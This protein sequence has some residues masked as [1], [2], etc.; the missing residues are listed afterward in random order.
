MR[1]LQINF[2]KWCFVLVNFSDHQCNLQNLAFVVF[3]NCKV[4]YLMR[5][6]HVIV[7]QYIFFPF[8][9]AL[10]R[11][12]IQDE[13]DR[14]TGK[15]KQISPVPIHLSIYSPNGI[16]CSW[17]FIFHWRIVHI[18]CHD[19]TLYSFAVVNLTL[20]DLPGLT[21]VAVGMFF[22]CVIYLI[23]HDYSIFWKIFI[24]CY[25]FYRGTTWEHCSRNWEYG[26]FL[27]WE[28]NI[29]L[30]ICWLHILLRWPEGDTL[31]YDFNL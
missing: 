24:K 10:V 25:C 19:L 20:I 5:F 14:V 23:L 28:G 3:W 22:N 16:L 21:K 8:L 12:E 27:C 26:S 7:W 18:P 29:R 13:T 30:S 15:T 9:S 17:Y 11:K 6:L 2:F 1:L 31:T 4:G